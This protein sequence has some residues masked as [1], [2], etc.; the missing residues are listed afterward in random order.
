MAGNVNDK[1]LSRLLMSS[2]ENAIKSNKKRIEL[3]LDKDS[4][5]ITESDSE[6]DSDSE[7]EY[8]DGKLLTDESNTEIFVTAPSDS[9]IEEDGEQESEKISTS[10]KSKKGFNASAASLNK[11]ISN[12][13][14]THRRRN[15]L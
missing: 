1:N 5:E 15:S 12:N 11:A 2:S 7:D 6:D 4:S 3:I 13:V 9:D 14:N 8:V 10:S